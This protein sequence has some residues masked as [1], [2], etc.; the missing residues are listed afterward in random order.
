VIALA[1]SASLDLFDL[2]RQSDNEKDLEILILRQ[3]LDILA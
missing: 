2:S 1:F 3:Q